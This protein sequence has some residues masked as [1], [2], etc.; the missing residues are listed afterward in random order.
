MHIFKRAHPTTEGL[1]SSQ[2]REEPESVLLTV[3]KKCFRSLRSGGSAA[4]VPIE[5]NR[6]ASNQTNL[7]ARELSVFPA[8]AERNLRQEELFPNELPQVIWTIRVTSNNP[9]E[10]PVGENL[11]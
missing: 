6:V 1:F 5:T 3:F 7:V 11:F 4:I 2:F 9:N 10:I 8:G